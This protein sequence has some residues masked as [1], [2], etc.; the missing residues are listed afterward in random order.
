MHVFNKHTARARFTVEI[1]SP[2]EAQVI[3]GTPAIELES[4]TDAHVPVSV[5]IARS[6]LQTPVDLVLV[7]TDQTN[8]TAREKTIRFLGK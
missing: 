5:S 2:V 4:L 7:V 1:R 3:I 8:G 6:K